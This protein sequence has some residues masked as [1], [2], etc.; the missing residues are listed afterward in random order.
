MTVLER[1]AFNQGLSDGRNGYPLNPGDFTGSAREAY[2]RG[3]LEGT[4]GKRPS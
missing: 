4:F 3:Y 2:N 1:D